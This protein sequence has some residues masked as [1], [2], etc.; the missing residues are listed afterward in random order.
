MP[1]IL[2][3]GIE[4]PLQAALEHVTP[5]LSAPPPGKKKKKPD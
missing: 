1:E 5:W 3:R 4:H 2:S